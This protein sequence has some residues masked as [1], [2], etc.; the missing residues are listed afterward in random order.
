MR[1]RRFVAGHGPA[2]SPSRGEHVLPWTRGG[3]SS[4]PPLFRR[5]PVPPPLR[6]ADPMVSLVAT[7]TR[8]GEQRAACPSS[9]G[10]QYPPPPAGIE[11]SLPTPP[12]ISPETPGISRAETR[13]PGTPNAS[14]GARAWLRRWR[15]S[16]GYCATAWPR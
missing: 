16:G 12:S 9:V 13:F 5:D 7:P 2:G 6:Y 11:S 14:H 15:C 3:C 8:H 10:R 4:F 1:A